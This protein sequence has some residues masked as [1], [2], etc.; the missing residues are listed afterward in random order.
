MYCRSIQLYLQKNPKNPPILTLGSDRVKSFFANNVIDIYL[1]FNITD[2]VACTKIDCSTLHPISRVPNFRSKPI[3]KY[4][5]QVKAKFNR[6]RFGVHNLCE[7]K[8]ILTPSVSKRIYQ[9]LQRSTLLY[10]IE[11]CDWDLDQVKELE[12]L[13]AK[14][15]RY[16]LGLDLQC[17]KA[18]LR[19]VLGVGPVEARIDLHVLLYY[20]K[21]CHTE[22]DTIFGRFHRYRSSNFNALPVG[23]YFTAYT[24]LSKIGLPHLWNNIPLNT[25]LKCILKKHI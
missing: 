25:G 9:T 24:T 6:S 17:P 10:C 13:Q 16:H 1:G 2:I 18:L 7:D 22:A 8:D 12:I 19:L 4:L 23:F 21:L 3:Q 14:A 5:K 20:V 11:V 15:I